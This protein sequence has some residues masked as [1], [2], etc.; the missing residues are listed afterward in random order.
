MAVRDKL[1]DE[2]ARVGVDIDGYNLYYALRRLKGRRYLWLD[3][4]A[5]A[6]RLL[7]EDQIL[8]T[9]YYFTAPVRHDSAALVRQRGYLAA[10]ECGGDVKVVLGRFQEQ[11]VGCRG[12]GAEWRT[13][14]EK[15][16]DVAIA[17]AMVA[18][19]ALDRVDA[20]LLISADSDLCAGIHTIREIDAHRGTKTRIVAVFPREAFRPAAGSSRRLVPPR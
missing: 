11:R 13:Y 14:E 5:L 19:V 9:L 1:N 20:V 3:L 4:V 15:Q 17:T 7:K 12:C 10:L 2:P 18:D 16:T 6:T 8:R